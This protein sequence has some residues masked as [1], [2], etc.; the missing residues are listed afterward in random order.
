MNNTFEIK[1]L[2]TASYLYCKSEGFI[3]LKPQGNAYLFTFADYEK[4]SRLVTEYLQG[5]GKVD[6]KDYSEAIKT[7][8]GLI[9]TETEKGNESLKRM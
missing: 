8:K 7:L 4:C 1:D 2:Y 5:K 3:G 9:F 6:A